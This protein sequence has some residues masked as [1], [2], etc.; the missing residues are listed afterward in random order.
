LGENRPE[1]A[2]QAWTAGEALARELPS[3]GDYDFDRSRYAMVGR[4]LNQSLVTG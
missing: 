1:E 3:A 4:A 2:Q